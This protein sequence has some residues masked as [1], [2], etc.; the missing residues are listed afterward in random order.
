MHNA[1]AEVFF[2][3]VGKGSSQLVL[4][5]N[6]D[7]VLIDAGK[8]SQ[9]VIRLVESLSITRF[10]SVVI[11]H[12]HDDHCGGIPNFIKKFRDRICAV[13]VPGK[14]ECVDGQAM[15][16][17]VYPQ[18]KTPVP[19]ASTG[20]NLRILYPDREARDD[21]E[22]GNDTN[23]ASGILSLESSGAQV[24][25]PG[26]A[27][28]VAFEMLARHLGKSLPLRPD[29]LAAPH[30]AGRSGDDDSSP[31][32]GY[33]NDFDWL[34]GDCVKPTQTIISAGTVKNAKHPRP[35][36]VKAIR[37]TGSCVLYTQ[38]TEQCHADPSSLRP[39]ILDRPLYP[40]KHD[41]SGT[42]CAGTI[43]A[44]VFKDRVEV[45]R[46]AEHQTAIDEKLKASPAL[47]RRSL[48]LT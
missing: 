18:I 35:A 25:F 45:D 9:P 10:V 14:P 47:C 31:P 8:N 20:A 34:Y 29:L 12:W 16:R 15:Y 26:D 2:V 19:N 1:L 42:A 6:G 46:L 4:F 13:R 5:P 22:S 24:L 38:L 43:K 28:R 17:S 32:I 3:D 23:Q 7:A 21:A 39:A 40:G 36:H 37:Q 33:V 30:H 41:T 11:S 44:I 27:G 48:L